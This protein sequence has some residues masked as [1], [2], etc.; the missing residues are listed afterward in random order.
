MTLLM[1]VSVCPFLL[2]ESVQTY[3]KFEKGKT[4]RRWRRLRSEALG[5]AGPG[6]RERRWSR[7]Q[8]SS[9]LDTWTPRGHP[10]PA[11]PGGS[12][13]ASSRRQWAPFG[14]RV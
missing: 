13:S 14:R 9:C 8:V 1:D 5:P 6:R 3:F 11:C 7:L 2:L 4:R 12:V 10:V